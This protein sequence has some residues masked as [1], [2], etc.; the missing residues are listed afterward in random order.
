MRSF[1]LSPIRRDSNWQ[2]ILLPLI[3]VAIVVFVVFQ[4]LGNIDAKT[5]EERIRGVERAVMR[6]TVQC[7][8]IEGQ[9]PASYRHLEENYGLM[10]DDDKYIVHFNFAGGNFMPNIIVLERDF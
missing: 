3:T 4:G 5:E 1:S 9:Y 2:Q 7:Y 6:A 10:V 8:A